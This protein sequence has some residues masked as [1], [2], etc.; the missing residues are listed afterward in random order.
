M[1]IKEE[2]KAVLELEAA[3]VEFSKCGRNVKEKEK[4]RYI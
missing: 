2:E 3:V 4:Y 1:A